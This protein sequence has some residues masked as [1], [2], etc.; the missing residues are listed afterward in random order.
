MSRDHFEKLVLKNFLSWEKG[1]FNFHPGV[2]MFIGLS[3]GGK[4]AVMDA[5]F[6]LFYNRPMGTD[7]QSWWGGQTLISLQTSGM[8]V[9]YKKDKLASY[10][11]K[12]LSTGK[13]T[14]FDAPKTTVPDQIT[15][16]L[17]MD[18][19]INFQ[20][21]LEKK[22]PIFLLSESPSDIS[23]HLNDVARLENIDISLDKGKKEVKKGE[24][25]QKVIDLQIHAK[26]KE[27]KKYETLDKLNMLISHA[28]K[29]QK[30]IDRDNALESRLQDSLDDY[31]QAKGKLKKLKEKLVVAPM[32]QHASNLQDK[33]TGYDKK[34]E[35]F[36]TILTDIMDIKKTL[37]D[38]Q[39]K[40][41]LT[42]YIRRCS[43]L[44]LIIAE[45]DK[46]IEK[47]IEI[48]DNII[49]TKDQIRVTKQ[50]IK[51]GKKKL[52]KEFPDI[53]PL[54]NQTVQE[55]LL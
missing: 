55:D 33:I 31:T 29:I 25:E 1:V 2:N 43:N 35:S 53:C 28:E 46:K 17:N 36:D 6:K 8:K 4:S 41:E 54:C 47:L 12:N 3:D 51:M 10:E 7:F 26:T 37:K 45:Y 15:N 14:V 39:D 5:F 19:K 11:M 13:L 52:K 16:F 40:K 21:Q 38:I 22:A 42:P 23:K 27:L 24:T 48:K 18:R 20:K 34:I 30:N 9:R 44:L 50:L 49:E 32:I